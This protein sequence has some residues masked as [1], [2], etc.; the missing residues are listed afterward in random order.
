MPNDAGAAPRFDHVGLAVRDLEAMTAWYCE[1]FNMRVQHRFDLQDIGLQIAMLVDGT[2]RRFELLHRD[3]GV[4][5]LRAENPLVAAATEGYGHACF[6]VADLPG[7]FDAT[8]GAGAS[9]GVRPAA[10]A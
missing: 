6:V 10:V 8:I 1:R 5:G 4:P 9:P 2:G 7:A 3:G